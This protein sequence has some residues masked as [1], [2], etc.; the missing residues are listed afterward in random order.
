MVVEEPPVKEPM[1]MRKQSKHFIKKCYLIHT[2]TLKQGTE[3][4][5]SKNAG[6][7]IL[8]K[9]TVFGCVIGVPIP[10]LV[11]EG[12]VQEATYN[13]RLTEKQELESG[14]ERGRV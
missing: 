11:R 3:A 7:M 2:A 12:L 9:N 14:V 13:T 1:I 4:I 8:L 10:A 6:N 5:K